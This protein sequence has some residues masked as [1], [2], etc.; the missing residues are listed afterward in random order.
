MYYAY[1]KHCCA[2]LHEKLQYQ[3][4]I[5]SEA[6]IAKHYQTIHALEQPYS[7]RNKYKEKYEEYKEKYEE[8]KRRYIEIQ[9]LPPQ[10]QAYSQ[11]KAETRWCFQCTQKQT[12]CRCDTINP[13]VF[14]QT[15]NNLGE[16]CSNRVASYKTNRCIRHLTIC[17]FEPCEEPIDASGEWKFCSGHASLSNVIAPMEATPSQKCLTCRKNEICELSDSLCKTCLLSRARADFKYLTQ[18]ASLAAG[19]ASEDGITTT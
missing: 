16:H 19:A 11:Q 13:Y 18:F 2:P 17:W 4:I 8:Y 3:H 7:K 1:C 14:C 12:V 9:T 6:L 5:T 15:E 10:N